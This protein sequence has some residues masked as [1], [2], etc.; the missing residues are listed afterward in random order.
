[1]LGPPQ[2]FL[3]AF[4]AAS[5]LS[6]I[7]QHSVTAL[8]AVPAMVVSL[9][10]AA[11]S[12]SRSGS[13]QDDSSSSGYPSVRRVLLGGGELPAR[14]QWRLRLLFPCAQLFTAYGM[15]EACSSITFSPLDAPRQDFSAAHGHTEAARPAGVCVGVP[16]PGI[17]V[18]ILQLPEA[19]IDSLQDTEA[20]RRQPHAQH[21]AAQEGGMAALRDQDTFAEPGTAG[22]VLTRGPHVMLGYWGNAS[23]SARAMLQPGGWLRTGDLGLM[24]AR[25]RLWLLGRLKDVVRSGSENVSAAE[26]E[27]VLNRLPGVA[28]AAVVG[29]PHPR[30]GEQVGRVA[31]PGATLTVC[32]TSV[33][34]F[35]TR[36]FQTAWYSVCCMYCC[37]GGSAACAAR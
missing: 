12:S 8:I 30:L 31:R 36:S 25:G 15:T 18:A 3:P 21:A 35:L 9:L 7:E 16:P 33:F 24:D 34:G 28:A 1:M 5:A 29:L 37:A 17:D 6:L 11:S 20:D 22:E 23:A 2:V 4:D 10:D 14:L 27:R 19:A 13:S 32:K 26:V